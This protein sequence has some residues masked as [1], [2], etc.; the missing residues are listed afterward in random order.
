[1]TTTAKPRNDDSAT[2]NTE[3]HKQTCTCWRGLKR[4]LM[5]CQTCRN[6]GCVLTRMGG[7]YVANQK[8]V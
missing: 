3:L 7:A 1:M 6:W 8:L 2:T 4:S 5:A